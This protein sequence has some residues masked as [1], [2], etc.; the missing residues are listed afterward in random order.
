MNSWSS[1]AWAAP[2][3]VRPHRRRGCSAA[4]HRGRIGGPIVEPR[5][6]HLRPDASPGDTPPAAGRWWVRAEKG[7]TLSALPL[8]IELVHAFEPVEQDETTQM[9]LLAW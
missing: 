4:E 9:S 7:A 1:R 8:Q 5:R 3:P 6:C 2:R